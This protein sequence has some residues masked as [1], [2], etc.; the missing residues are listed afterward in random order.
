MANTGLSELN[1]FVAVA[2]HRSFRAAATELG[3][4]A[5]AL[6]HAVSALE[7]R[8]GVRLFNRTTRSVAP[9][10]AG[11]RFLARVQPA[12]GEIAQAMDAVNDFRDTP[13]GVIRI[14]A[15]ENAARQILTPLILPFLERYPD[16]HVDLVTEGRFV[17][18]VADG[19]DAG[20][21]LAEAVPQD[22]V[23]IPFGPDIRF[24]VVGSPAYFAGR[25]V[26]RSP[27]D[28]ADHRCIR[29]RLPSGAVFRWEFEKHGESVTVDVQGPLKLNQHTLMIE[30]ALAGVGLAWV[31]E[32]NARD[33]IASGQLVRVLEDWTPPYPGLCLF[34]PR[35][36]HAPAGLR[37]F[38]DFVREHVADVEAFMSGGG[39]VAPVRRRS[40]RAR[41]ASPGTP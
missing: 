38:V 2:T 20:V 6:S 4:S 21:R 19:F 23:A 35:N 33:A 36:R 18:I 28:L 32:W 3:V 24:A 29:S 17:D 26:P 39:A 37:A 14:T 8:L 10:A 12:L 34:Y 5:S 25:T 7:R 40:A 9:T 13:T 30:A 27:A 41:P 31:N 11:A 15:A 1:A 16:M 22:M